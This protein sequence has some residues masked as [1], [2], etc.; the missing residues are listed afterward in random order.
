MFCGDPETHLPSLYKAWLNEMRF[1]E[2]LRLSILADFW[3]F[4][5]SLSNGF[6]GHQN[7]HLGFLHYSQGKIHHNYAFLR[8]FRKILKFRT[9]RLI[10]SILKKGWTRNSFYWPLFIDWYVQKYIIIVYYPIGGLF[11]Q[12]PSVSDFYNN[13]KKFQLLSQKRDESC[14]DLHTLKMSADI[15]I[16]EWAS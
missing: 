7:T 4:S 1:R 5:K 14:Y 2:L 15:Q 13:L 9:L 3:L 6:N 12:N 8:Y 10:S 16:S 11:A